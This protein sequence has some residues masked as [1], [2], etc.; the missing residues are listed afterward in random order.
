MGQLND[1]SPM[2]RIQNR[3]TQIIFTNYDKISGFHQLIDQLIQKSKDAFQYWIALK[4]W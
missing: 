4:I 1:S 3:D 2:E